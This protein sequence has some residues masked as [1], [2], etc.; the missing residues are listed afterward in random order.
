MLSEKRINDL[1][2]KNQDLLEALEEFDR[3]GQ[4]SK[5]SYK[6][7]VNFTIDM[8]LMR[9]FRSYC[10]KHNCKMSAI[11]EDLIREELGISQ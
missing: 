2:T 8:D 6:E 11:V 1:V 3:T 4:L 7:R 9:I 5:V 10:K